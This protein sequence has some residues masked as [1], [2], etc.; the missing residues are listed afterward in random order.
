MAEMNRR[1]MMKGVAAFVAAALLPSG[2][3]AAVD[4][5]RRSKG[6]RVFESFRGRVDIEAADNKIYAFLDA[7]ESGLEMAESVDIMLILQ[8][9]SAPTPW[10][11]FTLRDAK[12]HMSD[13]GAVLY[14]DVDMAVVCLFLDEGSEFP[15]LEVFQGY[16]KVVYKGFGFTRSVFPAE[17]PNR[18]LAGKDVKTQC[19]VTTSA[20]GPGATACSY[21]AYGYGCRVSCTKGYSPCAGPE[22]CGCVEGHGTIVKQ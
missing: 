8:R 7:T 16:R 2:V 4:T 13:R 14:S 3:S 15:D 10:P 9:T 5:E 17:T 1:E 18:V 22:G 21:F 11:E 19:P 20:G 12:L 6:L